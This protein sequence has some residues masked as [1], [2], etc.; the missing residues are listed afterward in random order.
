[1]IINLEDIDFEDA[2]LFM[3][4]HGVRTTGRIMFF[5]DETTVQL[6]AGG[7]LEVV[8]GG[9]VF[10]SVDGSLAC[11]VERDLSEK[12]YARLLDDGTILP[13]TGSLA[14]Q[15]RAA[16]ES[17]SAEHVK[18][19]ERRIAFRDAQPA[20][21]IGSDVSWGGQALKRVGEMDGPS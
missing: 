18:D 2:P 3:E 1:M 4:T 12:L 13:L 7:K 8:A 15:K 11:T 20:S 16:I 10:R 17:G 14:E 6:P 9:G 19:I 5:P 21:N